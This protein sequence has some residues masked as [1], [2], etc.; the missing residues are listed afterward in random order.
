MTKW[1][2]GNIRN[3][4]TLWSYRKRIED[5]T[6]HWLN[7]RLKHLFGTIASFQEVLQAHC[8][9]RGD[10]ERLMFIS[11]TCIILV[12]NLKMRQLK[13]IDSSWI[14]WI[15]NNLRIKVPLHLSTCHLI[16]EKCPPLKGANFV[17]LNLNVSKAKRDVGNNLG[18]VQA[19][20]TIINP[21]QIRK[22]KI[23]CNCH[24]S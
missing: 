18:L 16:L 14:T 19:R 6:Q 10:N 1:V 21:N 17:T 9:E 11:Y 5:K 23:A 2:R 4:C 24:T 12:T 13:Q 22:P 15:E 7:Q 20:L 8:R 3:R